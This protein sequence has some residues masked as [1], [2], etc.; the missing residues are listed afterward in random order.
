MYTLCRYIQPK[1]RVSHLIEKDCSILIKV[2]NKTRMYPITTFDHV[3]VIT[4]TVI[5]LKQYIQGIKN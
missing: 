1:K 2:T 4:T 5:M 3:A